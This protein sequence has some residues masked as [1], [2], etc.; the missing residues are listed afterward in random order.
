MYNYYLV[1]IK[2]RGKVFT[3]PRELYEH[4]GKCKQEFKMSEWSDLRVLEYPDSGR[5]H[6]HTIVVIHN[7][8]YWKK[9]LGLLNTKRIYIHL[10]KFDHQDYD[11]IRQYLLK[12]VPDRP[13]QQKLLR[14]NL[15][16]HVN[17]FNHSCKDMIHEFRALD[18]YNL[19]PIKL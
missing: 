16:Q 19:H 6:M 9:I 12:Q 8:I 2:T 11:K 5:L 14:L 7:S 3:T 10:K 13:E 17:L 15:F 18:N 1:T 4:W